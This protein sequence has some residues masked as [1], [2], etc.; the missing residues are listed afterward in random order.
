VD[1]HELEKFAELISTRPR[2]V[3]LPHFMSGFGQLT[4]RFLLDFGSFRDIQRH[5][6]GVCR[7]PL[8]TTEHGFEPWYL[9][10]LP[11]ALAQEAENLIALQTREIQE[12]TD[13]PVVRQYYTALG[14]RMPCQVTY[15]LPAAVYVME[16]RSSKHVHPTL[17]K[18]IHKMVGD[19]RG[20]LPQVPLHV[21]MD[22]DGWT[23]RRGSQTITTKT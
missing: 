8:L 20:V 21:D 7:M 4:W 6:N 1:E 17:R 2:G 14:Y 5:R 3:V 22:P 19:F 18:A 23:V 15:A 16:I 13:D 9:E 11:A 10:Q 12:A